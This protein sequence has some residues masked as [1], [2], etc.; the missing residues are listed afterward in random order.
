MNEDHGSVGRRGMGETT[1][2]DNQKCT[3]PTVL[4]LLYQKRERYFPVPHIQ[5]SLLDFIEARS[6][7]FYSQL[8]TS[9]GV[10]LDGIWQLSFVS[11]LDL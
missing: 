6:G 1:S 9:E 4:F 3:F 7:L 5:S 11:Q 8:P 2:P 10:L